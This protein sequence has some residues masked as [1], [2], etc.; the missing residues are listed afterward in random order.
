MPDSAVMN[1]A[2]PLRSRRLLLDLVGTAENPL[3]WVEAEILFNLISDVMGVIALDARVTDGAQLD[4][5]QDLWRDHKLAKS[6]I[7]HPSMLGR[8]EFAKLLWNSSDLC[9]VPTGPAELDE[10]ALPHGSLPWRLRLDLGIGEVALLA[11]IDHAARGANHVEIF[12]GSGDQALRGR[13]PAVLSSV[14]SRLDEAQIGWCVHGVPHCIV[15]RKERVFSLLQDGY[16]LYQPEPVFQATIDSI[17][18]MSGGRRRYELLR[19]IRRGS[20]YQRTL[21]QKAFNG[22]IKSLGLNSPAAR[23]AQRLAYNA[24]KVFSLLQD[25]SHAAPHDDA[26]PLFA[27]PEVACDSH[28]LGRCELCSLRLICPGVSPT[29]AA[30]LDEAELVPAAGP[31]P[32]DPL[33]FLRVHGQTVPPIDVPRLPHSNRELAQHARSVV[34]D[35]TRGREI[36]SSS[37]KIHEVP[38][39]KMNGSIEWL[40]AWE[41]FC[42]STVLDRRKRPLTVNATFFG[43]ARYVGFSFGPSL[44]VMCPAVSDRHSVAAHVDVHGNYVLLRDGEEVEAVHVPLQVNRAGRLPE[45]LEPTLAAY[46]I[47]RSMVTQAVFL[48]DESETTVTKRGGGEAVDLSV[49]VV[50]TKYSRRLGLLARSIAGQV[51]FDLSRAELIVAYVPGLDGTEDILDC[52]S[53]IRPELGTVG[54][55][56]D[57]THMTHKG[58]MIN[59]AVNHATGRRVLI[60]DA[61]IIMPPDLLHRLESEYRDHHFVAVEGRKMLDAKTTAELLMGLRDPVTDFNY[62]RDRAPGEKRIGEAKNTPIG[63]FQCVLRTHLRTVTY[64]E[65]SHF[66]GADMQFSLDIR[67]AFGH[68]TVMKDTLV[69]HQDHAGSRWYGTQRQF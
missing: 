5:L 43:K 47:D 12:L 60:T 67:Q 3:P 68:E 64:G 38:F 27:C 8:R 22:A 66:E 53:H 62:L 61:D 40:P 29:C 32:T 1:A 56:F 31:A 20:R 54:V 45:R 7:V 4:G 37:Y 33:H 55:P 18:A 30:L 36:K 59:Q 34:G 2:H 25:E 26:P 39:N 49:V 11:W 19:V 24:V 28:H 15:A 13:L 41:R 65:H 6:L 44:Q 52:L 57:A 23:F 35:V 10:G 16:C 50:C 48:W 46:G 69:L 9:L 17:I 14:T 63:Y 42:Q 58:F 21:S 51:D